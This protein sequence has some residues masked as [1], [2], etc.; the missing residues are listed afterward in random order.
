[1]VDLLFSKQFVSIRIRLA[2]I[3]SFPP[4]PPTPPQGGVVGGGE[5]G[6][7]YIYIKTTQPFLHVGRLLIFS[8][9]H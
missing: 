6:F 7:L 1:M 4:K 2:L 8:N 3:R 5:E 9:C